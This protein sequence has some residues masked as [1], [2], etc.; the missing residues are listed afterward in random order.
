MQNRC[1]VPINELSEKLGTG[2]QWW[3]IMWVLG[4]GGGVS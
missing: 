4:Y 3:Y 1:T 2:P